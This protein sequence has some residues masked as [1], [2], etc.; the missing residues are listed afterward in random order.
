MHQ[1]FAHSNSMF[2]LSGE[3]TYT[4][5]NSKDNDFLI[6]RISSKISDGRSNDVVAGGD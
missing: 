6:V 4:K 1:F 5:K 3:E 2:S